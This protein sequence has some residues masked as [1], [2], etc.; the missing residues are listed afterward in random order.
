MCV[1]LLLHVK[2]LT[3][4]RLALLK[5]EGCI[6]LAVK[7]SQLRKEQGCNSGSLYKGRT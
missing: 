6:F 7:M 5:V 3:S 4:G 1:A 2:A